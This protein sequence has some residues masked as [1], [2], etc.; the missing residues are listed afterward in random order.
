MPLP[1]NVRVIDTLLDLPRE[2]RPL[3]E[4]FSQLRDEGSVGGALKTPAGYMFKQTPEA[5]GPTERRSR[6]R[7][8][9][10]DGQVQHRNRRLQSLGSRL[11]RSRD[12][13]HP[14]SLEAL[15]PS[16]RGRPEP[17]HGG[18]PRHRA[19]SRRARDRR[20]RACSRRATS[21]RCRSTTRGCTR[22]TRSASSSTSR[23]SATHGVPGPRV[24]YRRRR[25]WR[26][27]TRCCW[28]FPELQFV[29][30]PRLRAVDRARGEAAA[31]VAEPLLLDQRLRARSTTRR[32]SSTSRTRAAPTRSCTRATTRWA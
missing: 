11:H 29:T 1:K 13:G 15:S 27:S 25:T 24:P 9:A 20:R 17:R 18:H 30:A 28:F 19:G 2:E 21:R 6:G 5:R 14:A 10:G 32:R 7:H 23:S 26:S 3:T 12:D 8:A 16:A 22:S 31:E 4:R